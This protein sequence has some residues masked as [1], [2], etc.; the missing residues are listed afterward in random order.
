MYPKVFTEQSLATGTGATEMNSVFKANQKK[1]ILAGERVNQQTFSTVSSSVR[2]SEAASSQWGGIT[3]PG[4]NPEDRLEDSPG[5]AG[6]GIWAAPGIKAWLVGSAP[7]PPGD[8]PKLWKTAQDR[9][10][11]PKSPW[12]PEV[13]LQ[14][15]V[16]SL[17][18]TLVFSVETDRVRG[19]DS[20]ACGTESL[21]TLFHLHLHSCKSAITRASVSRS[22]W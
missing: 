5:R 22:R 17:L 18:E 20:S 6:P 12:T 7:A 11:Q 14:V 8:E 19:S 10:Q 4:G 13:I 3:L 1:K 21:H 2:E 9:T 16:K 15:T